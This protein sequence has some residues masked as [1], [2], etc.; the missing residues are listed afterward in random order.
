MFNK[1]DTSQLEFKGETEDI[2][3][4]TVHIFTD[5]ELMYAVYYKDEA[6]EYV[7]SVKISDVKSNLDAYIYTP[8]I[9]FIDL[10]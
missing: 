3:H 9:E 5:D 6:D 8:Y 7:T 4:R 2:L 1:L 10:I